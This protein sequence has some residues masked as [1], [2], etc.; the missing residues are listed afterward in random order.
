M[1]LTIIIISTSGEHFFSLPRE[2]V[3]G[4]MSDRG[5]LHEVKVCVFHLFS[6][7]SVCHSSWSSREPNR[8]FPVTMTSQQK[9]I[10]HRRLKRIKVE[11][12]YLIMLL[13]YLVFFFFRSVRHIGCY[14]CKRSLSEHVPSPC[15]QKKNADAILTPH[16]IIFHPQ[17][18]YIHC[19]TEAN[20]KL[21][22]RQNRSATC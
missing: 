2:S 21:K 15:R 10:L 6:K 20:W 13:C 17:V 8:F 3:S 7:V 16:L 18:I 11:N 22:T 9:V 5:T 19:R 12:H 14:S 1:I 4:T